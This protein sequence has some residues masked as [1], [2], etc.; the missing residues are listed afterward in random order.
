CDHL[1]V[2]RRA[3]IA[4]DH[5]ESGRLHAGSLTNSR[6]EVPWLVRRIIIAKSV[7]QCPRA[8]EGSFD[9]G[10]LKIDAGRAESTLNKGKV[11]AAPDKAVIEA[12]GSE[13]EGTVPGKIRTGEGS[14]E[15]DELLPTLGDNFQIMP[16]SETALYHRHRVEMPVAGQDRRPMPRQSL[17]IVVAEKMREPASR[18]RNE[19][20]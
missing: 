3:E 16:I 9:T 15:E 18:Q 17:R 4:L 19:Q 11:P 20:L 5:C 14:K 8:C 12:V 10:Q 6:R 2:A 1:E 13:W 7:P